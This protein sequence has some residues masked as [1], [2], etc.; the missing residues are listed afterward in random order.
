MRFAPLL[1]AAYLASPLDLIPDF[2]PFFGDLDDLPV[3]S[4]VLRFMQR[5]LPPGLLEG[6]HLSRVREG[7][8]VSS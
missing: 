3:I 2:V 7:A 8:S 4:L 1:A 5:S 6:K